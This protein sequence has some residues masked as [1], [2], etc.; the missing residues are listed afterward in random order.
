MCKAYHFT[1][2]AGSC[3]WLGP[4]ESLRKLRIWSEFPAS[5]SESESA[6]GNSTR[7]ASCPNRKASAC[8]AA[9]QRLRLSKWLRRTIGTRRDSRP[10]RAAVSLSVRTCCRKCIVEPR[11]AARRAG[12]ARRAAR[13]R[14]WTCPGECVTAACE[15]TGMP[16]LST[17]RPSHLGSSSIAGGSKS[18]AVK[19][20]IRCLASFRRCFT[21]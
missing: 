21:L 16:A 2:L 7:L 9:A 19:A 6:S 1:S 18:S 3:K 5:A 20:L 4:A 17:T 12:S 14:A 10:R 8:L 11:V 13:S 15:R